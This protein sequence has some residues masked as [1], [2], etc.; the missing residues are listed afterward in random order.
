MHSLLEAGLV[1]PLIIAGQTGEELAR[2]A[3]AMDFRG[4]RDA[5]HG[6]IANLLPRTITK[7]DAQF[8]L[9]KIREPFSSL[10]E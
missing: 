10:Q 6:H 3:G 2:N 9:A 8:A 5:K 1:R 4:Y 7:M